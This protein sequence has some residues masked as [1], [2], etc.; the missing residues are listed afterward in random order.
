LSNTA[1]FSLAA[2]SVDIPTECIVRGEVQRE[3]LVNPN[4]GL[5]YAYSLKLLIPGVKLIAQ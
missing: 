5:R 1:K 4:P 2:A 3:M